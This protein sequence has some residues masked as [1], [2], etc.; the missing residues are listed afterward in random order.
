[1]ASRRKTRKKRQWPN[2]YSRRHRSGEIGFVVDVGLVNGR[3]E[4]HSF[5]TKEDADSFAALKRTERLN[6]GTAALGLSQSA[7]MD[8][9]KALEILAPHDVTL[10]QSAEYYAKHVLAYRNAPLI[11]EVVAR[12]IADAEKNDRRDRT[13]E[14]LRSRLT[15]FSDDFKTRRLSEITGE[16][17]EAWLDEDDWSPRTRINYLTKISQLFNYGL[18]HRW[19]DA[20][21]VERIE[22]PT[23][24]DKEPGILSL[25]QASSL[26]FHADRYGLL[27]Y[28][29]IGLFAGLRSAELSRLDWSAINLAENSI[30]VGAQIAKK[31]SRRVVEIAPN[32][33]A[34]LGTIQNRQGTLVD[35]DSYRDS[36]ED[37]RKAA[38]IAEWPH[39]ALRHS[40]ASYHLAA[41]GDAMRTATILGHKDP[42]VVH[43][44]YKALVVKA[45]ALKFWELRPEATEVATPPNIQGTPK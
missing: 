40:F 6:E 41:F 20:N 31:R 44:H 33:Q 1:M 36:L 24:E 34:W 22:R 26:L 21:I 15:T 13:V 14:E 4:R 38:G 39:N 3:R 12:L 19:V 10:L 29:A 37:L 25:E 35:E 30:V 43:N 32:L 9:S 28:V 17:I 11:P 8:A 45:T 16:E 27:P 2:V 42:G 7:R 18:R 5:K 23:A